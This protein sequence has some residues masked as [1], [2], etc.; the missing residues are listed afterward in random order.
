MKKFVSTILLRLIFF[1]CFISNSVTQSSETGYYRPPLKEKLSPK[2]AKICNENNESQPNSTPQLIKVWIYFTD[3]QLFQHSKVRSSLKKATQNLTT[4][5]LH[6]RAKVL[7]P[8]RLVDFKD[9]SVPVNYIQKIIKTGVKHLA[10]R[11][12]L[13][14][15]S[16][17]ASPAQIKT[18]EKLDFVCQ[19]KLVKGFKRTK[20]I[21]GNTQNSFYK[22][23][24]PSSQTD[25]NYGESYEQLQ[26]INVPV[27]HQLGY[28]GKKVLVCMM[29]T[30]FR[31]DHEIFQS[32]NLI[33]ERDF[34][35]DD[36]DTQTDPDDPNDSS[37]N[38]GTV[39]WSTLGGYKDGELIGPAFGADFLLAKTEDSR[40]ETPIEE[41]YWVEGIEWADSL[42]AQIISCSLGYL[43][44]YTYADMDGNTAV[45]TI[46]ADR[47]AKL[48]I[49]VVTANGN[50]RNNSW[51]HVIAPADGDSVI[52]VGAVKADGTYA[53]FT[54]PGPTSDGRIK[55]EI[56]ARG[57]STYCA[58][59]Y[60]KDSY[61]H[62]NGTSLSTPLAA[63]VAALLLEIHPEWT[64]MQ[65]REALMSTASNSNTPDNDYG[66]G[67][68][69]ALAASQF[70]F[71]KIS[72]SKVIVDDDSLDGTLGNG[73]RMLDPGEIV[74]LVVLLSN[75]GEV[76]ISNVR[77]NLS[78]N[79]LFVTVLDSA[80]DYGNLTAGMI[81][82]GATAFKIKVSDKVGEKFP[83]QFSLSIFTGGNPLSTQFFSLITA[84]NYWNVAGSIY[85]QKSGKM[86]SEAN[87]V[88]TP[89]LDNLNYPGEKDTI[90]M[91]NTL[92]NFNLALTTGRYAIQAYKF[93]YLMPDARII[94]ANQNISDL[95]F[96]FKKPEFQLLPDTIKVYTNLDSI[97]SPKV[98]IIN[99]GTGI[100]EGNFLK[101]PNSLAKI[102]LER[103]GSFNKKTHPVYDIP[104]IQTN[105][106]NKSIDFSR[107]IDWQLL[108]TDANDGIQFDFKAVSV[109]SDTS[110]LFL[111]IDTHRD[112]GGTDRWMIFIFLD[113]LKIT[114]QNEFWNKTAIWLGTYGNLV[115]KIYDEK[116][117][118]FA[119]TEIIITQN[120]IIF[121]V[122]LKELEF[123]F[124]TR[125]LIPISLFFHK[126]ITINQLSL[127]DAI[128]DQ[129]LWPTYLYYSIYKN[130]NLELEN[131]HFKVES[132]KPQEV[133][134]SIDSGLFNQQQNSWFYLVQTNSPTRPISKL[135]IIFEPNANLTQSKEPIPSTYYLAHNYPNPFNNFTTI[136]FE[137]PLTEQ[138]SLEI[139]NLLGQKLR[140]LR[141]RK[142]KNGVH[143]VKW[144]G[145]NENGDLVSSG[146]Y[147]YKFSTAAFTQ[148]NKLVFLK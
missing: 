13:N 96:Y 53:N 99:T 45:T 28:N 46:A 31:K 6:R 41:D 85:E 10:T 105:Q 97:S 19:L 136:K 122:P 147:V 126:C 127:Q 39:T 88:I 27:L 135:P 23:Q 106:K 75:S 129:H 84:E 51:G 93:G 36:N 60:Q 20:I 111:K 144:D 35:F 47:A 98:E 72:F 40:S 30:G 2:L 125:P 73:N 146:V 148:T 66:W 54:S 37:D 9:L 90:F 114:N 26:Q 21:A 107:E 62:A 32:V 52:A 64:A 110:S 59:R 5:A 112:L 123:D 134:F 120:Q 17:L 50:E 117:N 38:H 141:N 89:L 81:R 3:K 131:R 92:G 11:R 103:T 4:R 48:G 83:I 18:I 77:A 71:S 76:T 80:I 16:V 69:D 86:L 87:L 143:S 116:I 100:L 102:S 109:A 63:G 12:W 118:F 94:T 24:P 8:D 119:I 22:P 44:W 79:N 56:C 132:T 7:P 15:I 43:D 70:T 61:T 104:Q 91:N 14:A 101:V 145:R 74:N 139:Y 42:G 108:R 55:P 67:I 82:Q 78:C 25:I 95:N 57:V 113:T 68:I 115:Y 33:A 124:A 65:V 29:D 142:M 58:S 130:S 133:F 121:S 137:L 140:T 49:I 34:I 128:P 138:V 1:L